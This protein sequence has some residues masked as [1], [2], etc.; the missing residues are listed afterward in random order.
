MYDSSI[1]ERAELFSFQSVHTGSEG[2]ITPPPPYNGQW[3]SFQGAKRLGHKT[4]NA[5]SSSADKN[6]WSYTST[7]PYAFTAA[8]WIT[9]PSHYLNAPPNK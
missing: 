6:A 7:A 2:L 5:P 1:P 8:T 9:F 3:S 4:D